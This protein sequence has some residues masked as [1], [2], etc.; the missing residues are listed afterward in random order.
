MSPADDLDL[1]RA[2]LL[3]MAALDDECTDAE[4]DELK[5]LL[6]AQ[7]ALQTEWSRLQRVKEVTMTMDIA[8]P[9][10][11]VWDHYRRSVVHRAERGIAWVLIAVGGAILAAWA[12]WHWLE[13]WLAADVPIVVKIASGVLMTGLALLLVSVL[14]ERWV[15][16]RRDPYSKEVLR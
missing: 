13:S 1:D 12:L 15:L 6:A 14:R 9:P 8:G 3:M 10:E 16:H 11:E 4:R 5:A 7:P 2:H